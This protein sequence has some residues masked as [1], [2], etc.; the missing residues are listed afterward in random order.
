MQPLVPADDGKTRHL[1]PGT[2]LPDL[3]L[4]SSAG[5]EVNLGARSGLAVVY[6]YPW[7]GR[8]GYEDPPGWDDITGAHGSTPQTLGFRDCYA[9]FVARSVDVFGLSTQSQ[10]HHRE[11]AARLSVPFALLSDDGF[12]FQTALALPVFLAGEHTFLKRLTLVVQDG[13]I[14]HVFYPVD[15]PGTHALEVL[16]WLRSCDRTI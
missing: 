3:A 14:R 10:E 13:T 6:I 15:P 2:P 7:T 1:K 16:A 5:C 8:P 12:R 11:L 9:Q 4:P